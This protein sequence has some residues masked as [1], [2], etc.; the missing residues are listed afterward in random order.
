MSF[1]KNSII[2]LDSDDGTDISY[3]NVTFQPE[4]HSSFLLSSPQC[5]AWSK[6]VIGYYAQVTYSLKLSVCMKI[7]MAPI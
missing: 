5:T 1:G 4:E 3:K 6:K 2:K 7:K